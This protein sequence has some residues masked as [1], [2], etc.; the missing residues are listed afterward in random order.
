ML[1]NTF[2]IVSADEQNL[3]LSSERV[4]KIVFLILQDRKNIFIGLWPIAFESSLVW[5]VVCYFL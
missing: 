2:P 4:F 5:F 1:I 3:W